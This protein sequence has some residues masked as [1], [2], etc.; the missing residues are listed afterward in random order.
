M[1]REIDR[2]AARV[3]S[4]ETKLSEAECRIVELTEERD[5]LLERVKRLENGATVPPHTHQEAPGGP[6]SP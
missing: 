6:T 3:T 4:L 2:L 5:E 1:Q